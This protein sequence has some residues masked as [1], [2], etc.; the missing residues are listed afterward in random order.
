MA[1]DEESESP[2]GKPNENAEID[3]PKE[4]FI[5]VRVSEKM[6][7]RLKRQAKKRHWKIS[8]L[9]RIVLEEWLDE[10]E[11]DPIVKLNE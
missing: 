7:Q 1:S 4:Q 11:R 2:L 10:Q 9:V 6:H 3:D 8:A 5:A